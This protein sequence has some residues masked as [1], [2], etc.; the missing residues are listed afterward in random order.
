MI[1]S[2]QPLISTCL[3]S[4]RREPG[5]DVSVKGSIRPAR[6][7]PVSRATTSLPHRSRSRRFLR[8]GR[9]PRLIAVGIGSGFGGA[10]AAIRP[11]ALAALPARAR[12]GRRRCGRRRRA[13]EVEPMLAC[14]RAQSVGRGAD[15]QEGAG[16]AAA[17]AVDAAIVDV[18]HGDAAPGEVVDDPVHDRPVGDA[19]LPAAAMD[20]E[21]DR[22]RSAAGGQPEVGD[23]ERI[24]AVADRGGGPGPRP[25]EQIRPGHQPARRGPAARIG[26][27]AHGASG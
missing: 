21:H 19:G 23:L 20:H 14:M 9:P 6:A 10:A 5:T 11:A 4:R 26:G 1:R 8:S 18:P 12:G 3:Y 27:L 22:M 7:P 2:W 17:G 13:A 24:G 25:F 16:I 15:V